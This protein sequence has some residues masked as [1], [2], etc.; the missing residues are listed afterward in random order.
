MA[1]DKSIPILDFFSNYK[2]VL[3][4][5]WVSKNTGGVTSIGINLS[6]HINVRTLSRNEVVS[7]NFFKIYK[8]IN[9]SKENII[10][11][12]SISVTSLIWSLVAYIHKKETVLIEH[13]QLALHNKRN[14]IRI[15]INKLISKHLFVDKSSALEVKNNI[16]NIFVI[17]PFIPA[18][19]EE[20]KLN[21]N[22][23]KILQRNR[24][25]FGVSCYK[26]IEEN[27]ID[28]YGIKKVVDIAEK[29]NRNILVVIVSPDI[30]NIKLKYPELEDN[31]NVIFEGTYTN[32]INWYKAFN[33]FFRLPIRDGFGLSIYEALNVGTKVVC[34]NVTAR[35]SSD[36]LLNIS[37]DSDLN[38][39]CNEI[40]NFIDA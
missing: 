32:L 8:I 7:K 39:I 5:W 4:V 35:P 2:S 37:L 19:L 40:K 20:Y 12:N 27:G 9:S 11:L 26:F 16:K 3:Y 17:N 28:F 29:I 23:K 18:K 15:L 36:F 22:A 1:L 30:K 6:K 14:F 10:V 13:N 25:V 34:S 21:A 38:K 33:I 24:I 31:T